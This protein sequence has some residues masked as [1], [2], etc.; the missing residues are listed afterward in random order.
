M[1]VFAAGIDF[2]AVVGEEV[3][4]KVEN[5]IDADH[6]SDIV[7]APDCEC[8][9]NGEQLVFSKLYKLLDAVCQKR[10][11]YERIGPHRVILMYHRKCAEG[12]HRRDCDDHNPVCV[13]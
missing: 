2:F 12:V 9:S 6:I 1:S 5:N 10:Q 3:V 13:F 8:Q 4:E 7:V 11:E